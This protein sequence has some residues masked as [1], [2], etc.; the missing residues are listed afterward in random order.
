MILFCKRISDW[1]M[2]QYY[3]KINKA[4][5]VHLNDM[6]LVVL[7]F[8]LSI[9]TNIWRKNS[10]R[11]N[12]LLFTSNIYA[13]IFTT[14]RPSNN[15]SHKNLKYFKIIFCIKRF[16][17]LLLLW[18]MACNEAVFFI[19]VKFIAYKDTKHNVYDMQ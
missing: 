9:T 2:V 5:I 12:F 8:K 11:K 17:F 6:H 7:V 1:V 18:F 14:F 13:H 15:L 10:K 3:V 4:I 19:Q 16:I